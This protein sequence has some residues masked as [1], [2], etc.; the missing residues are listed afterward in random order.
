MTKGSPLFKKIFSCLAAS[1]TMA[2][3][4]LMLGNSGTLAW[5]PPIL[6]FSLVGGCLLCGL[7]YPF[8]WHYL[9]KK[10]RI[11]S[12]SIYRFLNSLVRYTIAFNL[13]AFGWKK[14]FG[15]Q[16]VVPAAI[17]EKPMN[18]QSGEWLT[19]F[20]F[21]FSQTYGLLLAGVQ[22]VGAYL[23]L[24]RKTMLLAAI[25]LFVFM[26]NLTLINFFYQM[27]AGAIVQS[28]LLSIGLLYLILPDYARLK[29]FFLQSLPNIPGFSATNRV[30]RNLI[31]LSAI[32]LSLLFTLYLKGLVH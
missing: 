21:G 4:L 28:L 27:N 22:L 26:F 8:V 17:A 25:I 23:L 2:A 7:V 10:Q 3:L 9:E 12:C 6:V 18:Q 1:L 19:W 13:A 30:T 29:Y 24:F 20:Y 16:F 5:F 11:N 32:V 15:L 31:R 14:I